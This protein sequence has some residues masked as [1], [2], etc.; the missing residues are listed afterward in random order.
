MTIAGKDA[1]LQR[2]DYAG[3][4]SLFLTCSTDDLLA[5]R[6]A[7]FY[8]GA[9]ACEPEAAEVT[10]IEA[11]VPLFGCDITED[12]LPQEIGR[13]KQAI[14]FTK[15]CYLGQETVARIDAL[16]MSIGCSRG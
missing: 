8:A 15:G 11:G 3:E 10:R 13:N 6:E 16:G 4:S 2:T 5:I 9:L 1:C 12:N 7:L 14:S